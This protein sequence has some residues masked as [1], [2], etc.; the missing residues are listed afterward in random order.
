MFYTL[1]LS[2][3]FENGLAYSNRYIIEEVIN[4]L[5]IRHMYDWQMSFKWKWSHQIE[6]FIDG[7]N[8][9]MVM[10]ITVKRIYH[11]HTEQLSLKDMFE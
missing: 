3:I 8:V 2:L 7:L 9:S 4:N 6:I 10:N 1:D 5:T 11:D